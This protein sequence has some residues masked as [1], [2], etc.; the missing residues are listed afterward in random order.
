MQDFTS[1]IEFFKK[2]NEKVNLISRKDINFLYEKHIYDS[3]AFNLFYE[4]YYTSFQSIKLLDIG[5]GGGFPSV[6]LA[7]NHP[8]FDITAVDS[9]QKKIKFLLELKEKYNLENLS[10]I[11]SRVE[12]L[13]VNMRCSY[14]VTV[15]RA[16][17]ELRIILEYGIPFIKKGG[18]FVAYKSKKS[19]EELFNAKNAMKILNTKLEDKIEY[20]LPLMEDNTR[21]LL[22]FKK[23]KDT[24][25]KYPRENGIVKKNPL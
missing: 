10:P 1:Y 11:A 9:I 18:F 22:I 17:S 24:D 4:K 6:P 3:L 13:P 20:K 14:D 15:T 8:N 16:M 19:D 7:F 21:Y 25:K 12:N 23:M 2:Y 5:T